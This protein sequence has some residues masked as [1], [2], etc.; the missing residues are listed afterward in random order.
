[1]PVS[2]Y[3]NANGTLLTGQ[4]DRLTSNDCHFHIRFYTGALKQDRYIDILRFLHF[5]DNNHQPDMKDENSDRLG[6]MRNLF[7][8]INNT[9]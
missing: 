2:C 8:I 6:E 9:F 5:T 7:E 3:N 1:M 4:T